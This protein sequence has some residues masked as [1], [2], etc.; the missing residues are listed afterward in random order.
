MTEKL[1][2]KVKKTMNLKRQFKIILLLLL[3]LA[4]SASFAINTKDPIVMMKTIS[5]NMLSSL[6]RNRSR[7]KQNPKLIFSLVNQ[8]L[9]PNVDVMGM[10]RSVIGRHAW[11]KA[12]PTQQRA[13]SK[14]FTY[15]VTK[16]YASA[17]NAYVDEKI[18]F[19]PMRE[20]IQGRRRIQIHSR[21]VRPEGPPIPVSYRLA[22]LKN[23]W[24]IYDLNVEGIGLL[25]SFHAQFASELA[26]GKTIAELTRELRSR[27]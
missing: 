16:T 4:C 22:W 26:Q 17:L 25:E 9:L 7:L 10:S 11:L 12:T 23:R 8:Y 2:K 6:K 1:Q 24:K 5:N 27:R 3:C 20:S 19:F 13:F 15:V 14:A 18:E 21:I